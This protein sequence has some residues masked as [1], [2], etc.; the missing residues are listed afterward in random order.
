MA[1]RPGLVPG[2]AGGSIA[3]ALN[4]GFLGGR[5]AGLLP[6]GVVMAIQ[7]V[8]I[9]V[10]LIGNPP[11]LYLVAVAAG[12]CVSTAVVV[13]LK[14]LRKPAPGAADQGAG[15]GVRAAGERKQPVAA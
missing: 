9:P 2:F 5:V 13:V 11:L 15:E 14:T 10:P 6:G 3:F 8:R 1:D 12:V 4:A 7:K